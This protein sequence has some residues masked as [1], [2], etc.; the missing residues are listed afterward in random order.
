[1]N[2]LIPPLLQRSGKQVLKEPHDKL[3]SE[4]TGGNGAGGLIF[5]SSVF[6]EW[7][8]GWRPITRFYDM[9]VTALVTALAEP[10]AAARFVGATGLG[11]VRLLR[12][13]IGAEGKTYTGHNLTLKP[14]LPPRTPAS[15]R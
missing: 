7:H 12:V 6:E 8:G 13:S 11:G 15:K 3:G 4:H 5:S 2:Q 9:P 14:P 1:M 10:V